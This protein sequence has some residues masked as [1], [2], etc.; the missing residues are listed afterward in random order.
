MEIVSP[1]GESLGE[2]WV[3]VMAIATIQSMQ[4]VFISSGCWLQKV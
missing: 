1:M 2:A 4:G 3:Y